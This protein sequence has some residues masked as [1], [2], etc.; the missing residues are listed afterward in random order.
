M[1]CQAVASRPTLVMEPRCSVSAVIRAG[2]SVVTS[3]ERGHQAPS[4]PFAGLRRFEPEQGG[5]GL[6]RSVDLV[7]E[8]GGNRSV[9]CGHDRCAYL[10][11]R[12]HAAVPLTVL[13]RLRSSAGSYPVTIGLFGLGPE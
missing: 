5:A 3:R 9:G 4:R 2:S 8:S 12:R 7:G 10:T 1:S 6:D 13:R 11:V